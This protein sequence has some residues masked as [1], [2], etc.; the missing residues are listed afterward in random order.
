MVREILLNQRRFRPLYENKGAIAIADYD[1][2]GDM[3]IFV[4]GKS[5]RI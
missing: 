3:D 1:K 4:G 2:D 5:Q